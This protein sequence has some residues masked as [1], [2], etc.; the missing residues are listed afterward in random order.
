MG[1]TP[2][3]IIVAVEILASSRGPFWGDKRPGRR[4]A[5]SKINRVGKATGVQNVMPNVFLRCVNCSHNIPKIVPSP[6]EVNPS[7]I[8]AVFGEH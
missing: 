7:P 8:S 1:Q 4:L 5:G 2:A 3:S 6:Q